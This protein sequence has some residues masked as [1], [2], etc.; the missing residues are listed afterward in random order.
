MHVGQHQSGLG[1]VFVLPVDFRKQLAKA[2]VE[3]R[4]ALE[5]QAEEVIED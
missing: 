1:A 4:L 2:L 3:N 5:Q